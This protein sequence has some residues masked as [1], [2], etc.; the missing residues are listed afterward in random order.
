MFL[1][2]SRI[3]YY[4][5]LL[6]RAEGYTLS[7]EH[8]WADTYWEEALLALKDCLDAIDPGSFPQF[9]GVGDYK[10]PILHE[11][12]HYMCQFGGYFDQ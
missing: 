9:D 12:H 2:L 5:S 1:L 4:L 6:E 8:R 11:A 3:C 10:F 7:P